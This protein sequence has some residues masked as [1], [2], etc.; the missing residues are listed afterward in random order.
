MESDKRIAFAL[1]GLAGNNAHGAGF[2]QAALDLQV[3]PGI[4][5][6]SSGQILWVY[7]YLQENKQKKHKPDLRKLLEEDIKALETTKSFD[8]DTAL[9]FLFGK[10]EVYRP[11][12]LEFTA[13]FMKN[14]VRCFQTIRENWPKVFITKEL[15][16][17]IPGRLLVPQFPEDFFEKISKAFDDE[18]KIGI[19][20]NSFD[21]RSGIEQVYVNGAAKTLEAESKSNYR[22]NT[23]YEDI[24]PGA[25]RDALKLYQYGFDE[26]KDG[27]L[28]GAYYRQIMLSELAF[29]TDIFVARPINYKWIDKSLPKG[30]TGIEDLKTKVAFNGS[31]AGERDKI[32]LIN[33][34]IDSG[35]LREPYKKINLIEIEIRLPRGYF[36]Y[37]YESLDVFDDARNEAAAQLKAFV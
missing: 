9:L 32:N 37:I 30:Y 5:S 11:A 10:A 27:H 21:P 24:K 7:R 8:I 6:L 14:S 16:D 26:S 4:I 28:D 25:V 36:D 23:K 20:F 13:D 22:L 3:E 15:A 1:G 34:L 18:S 19:V 35:S 12:F 31:Y 17:S 2:L 33:K 29:A